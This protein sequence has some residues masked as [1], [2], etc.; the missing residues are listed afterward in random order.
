MIDLEKLIA[1]ANKLDPLPDAVLRLV[2][3]LQKP[4]VELKEI[5]RAFAAD[6]ALTAQLL[7]Q[8]NS[9][10]SAAVNKIGTVEAAIVRLG[11]DSV[12]ALAVGAAAQT[13]LNAAAAQY[14]LSEGELWRHGQ[15]ARLAID[16]M[17][18]LLRVKIP[19]EAQ[20]AALLHDIGKVVM[21]RFLK[22]EVLAILHE[23]DNSD[24]A[25]SLAAEREVLQVHHG[26]LGGLI[27][28]RWQLPDQIV[29]G[30]IYHHTPEECTEI[31]NRICHLVCMANWIAN[32]AAATH[33]NQA[34]A[35]PIPAS[36][37]VL[38]ISRE[39]ADQLIQ[40]VLREY[41]G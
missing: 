8:A 32:A 22:P 11:L 41:A 19:P 1:S 2:E 17:R 20:T 33:A 38:K 4:E 9:A 7:R 29:R 10:S 6:G 35:E 36:A 18:R 13:H 31:D 34:I 23:A 12:L 21:A 39:Q 40:Y 15:Y 5:E 30:I 25:V 28:Q 27:A 16:G 37:E 26:E 14:G 24:V 3:L